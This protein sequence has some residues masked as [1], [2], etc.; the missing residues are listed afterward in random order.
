VRLSSVARWPPLGLSSTVERAPMK[1]ST[2]TRGVTEPIRASPHA[3][4]HGVEHTASSRIPRTRNLPS[5][6]FQ[7]RPGRP[8]PVSSTV[9]TAASSISSELLS[10]RRASRGQNAVPRDVLGELTQGGC[11]DVPPFRRRCRATRHTPRAEPTEATA[12]S[13]LAST[14]AAS[15]SRGAQ[16]PRS[17][18]RCAPSRVPTA[19]AA[20]RGAP[21]RPPSFF[22]P[23]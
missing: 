16:A 6:R 1:F 13:I 23:F 22:P 5:S 3:H 2:G 9:A 18:P 14:A 11:V 7:P 17:P 12:L 8:V 10:T 15:A 4:C 21:R 20:V 19:T